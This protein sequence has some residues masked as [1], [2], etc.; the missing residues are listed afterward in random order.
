MVERGM[1]VHGVIY[2]VGTGELNEL[3]ITEDDEIVEERKKA[4]KIGE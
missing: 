2:D 4:F 1:Q 3:E